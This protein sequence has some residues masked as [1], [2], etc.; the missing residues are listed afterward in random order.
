MKKLDKAVIKETM[1]VLLWTVG[2]SLVMN[3]VFVAISQWNLT[4][5]WGTLLSCTVSVLNFFLMGVGVQSIVNNKTL[6]EKGQK[7]RIRLSLYLRMIMIIAAVAVGVALE[8]FNTV[9]V[10]LP[11]FFPRISLFFRQ[12]ALAKES[13]LKL[14]SPIPSGE[15][16]E[17]GNAETGEENGSEKDS[18]AGEE[19]GE[20][21][22][23]T[24]EIEEKAEN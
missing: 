17:E 18:D 14:K 10:I 19:N 5:L 24:A 12:F 21:K 23:E 11:I 13:G 7:A 2:L 16:N 22:T 9:A 1:F 15:E 6:D 4:V 3:G 8:C 20:A